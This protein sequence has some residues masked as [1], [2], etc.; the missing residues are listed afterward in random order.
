MVLK[1]SSGIAIIILLWWI[2]ILNFVLFFSWIC[3]NCLPSYLQGTCWKSD[4]LCM[5][6]E[7]AREREWNPAI[8]SLTLPIVLFSLML[9]LLCLSLTLCNI[10]VNVIVPSR[11]ALA[12]SAWCLQTLHWERAFSCSWAEVASIAASQS[13]LLAVWLAVVEGDSGCMQNQL[14]AAGCLLYF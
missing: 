14:L 12:G 5:V 6:W 4:V 7:R 9:T 13:K 3:S 8:V 2:I 1:K 11:G 10:P